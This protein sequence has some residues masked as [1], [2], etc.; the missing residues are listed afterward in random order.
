MCIHQCPYHKDSCM[1]SCISNVLLHP[2]S[3]IRWNTIYS[4]FFLVDAPLLKPRERH[5]VNSWELLPCCSPAWSE[6]FHGERQHRG[7]ANIKESLWQLTDAYATLHLLWIG[8]EHAT[9]GSGKWQ[10][11]QS[12]FR[13]YVGLQYSQQFRAWNL[14]I[15]LGILHALYLEFLYVSMSTALPL[16]NDLSLSPTRK[17]TKKIVSFLIVFK[18]SI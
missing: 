7:P 5:K 15:F 9:H 12:Q 1:Y 2:T 11:D 16:E 4:V 3:V 13:G 18:E 8:G 10:H 14:R 6:L 17:P